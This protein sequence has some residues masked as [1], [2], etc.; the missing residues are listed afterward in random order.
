MSES[1]IDFRIA[2]LAAELTKARAE[3]HYEELFQEK[4]NHRLGHT[5][6]APDTAARLHS[7]PKYVLVAM[8]EH[9]LD[10]A[11]ACK[12][13]KP[14]TQERDVQMWILIHEAHREILQL[15]EAVKR[16]VGFS[17]RVADGEEKRRKVALER[18]GADPSEFKHLRQEHLEDS[19]LY[20]YGGGQEKRNF[21]N[22]LLKKILDENGYSVELQHLGPMLT[23]YDRR[24]KKLIE[25]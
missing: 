18:F 23:K 1:S 5:E 6:V 17:G 19:L 25:K 12:L 3:G 20:Q 7:L 24:L 11:I 16:K 8:I 9:L 10:R 4:L 13:A 14:S 22:R 21:R 15:Y 2:E